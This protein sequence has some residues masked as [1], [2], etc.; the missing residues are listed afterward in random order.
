MKSH[1]V[2]WLPLLFLS[3][4]LAGQGDCFQFFF[5]GGR[6]AFD[7]PDLELW[8]DAELYFNA[9]Y[10]C[11]ENDEAQKNLALEWK[12]KA[13]RKY[14][15]AIIEARDSVAGANVMIEKQARISRALSQAFLAQ[16]EVAK[17]SL[18]TAIGLAYEAY[19]TAG[20]N[21]NSS[22]NPL[23]RKSFGNT[24]YALGRI[25]IQGQ[26]GPIREAFFSPDGSMAL[27][28]SQDA[29]A[30]IWDAN[31]G[32]ALSTLSPEGGFLHAM[33]CSP[34]AAASSPLRPMACPASGPPTGSS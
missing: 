22:F 16:E 19:Q 20:E 13:R 1:V 26:S 5:S 10:Y 25:R 9:A 8:D 24:I 14:I 31:T 29:T 17:D 30:G 12:E 33:A 11:L 15:D 18:D 6:K 34:T 2:L 28:R 7:S 3:T 23:I 21:P 32:R 27:V 4:M